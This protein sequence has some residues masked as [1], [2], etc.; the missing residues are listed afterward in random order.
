MNTAKLYSVSLLVSISAGI[1]AAQQTDPNAGKPSVFLENNRYKPPKASNARLIQGMVK[2]QSDNPVA[3]AIVLLKNIKTTKVI[4]FATKED[5]KYTFKDLFLDAD[6]E[7][8]AKHGDLTTPVKKL[9]VYDTRKEVTIN[10]K[11]EPPQKQ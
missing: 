10:F 11:L 2:D 5:G 8:L 3:G 9:S 4:T 6:Y 1:A 7:L